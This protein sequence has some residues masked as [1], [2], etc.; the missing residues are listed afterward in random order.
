MKK[1]KIF[2]AYLPQYH[3]IPENNEFWGKGFTD[4]VGVKNA[5]PQFNGHKQPRKPLNEN[6]YDLSET[7]SIKWQA[8]L[9]R[10]YGV[11][12]FNIYHYWFEGGK[13]VLGK[14]AESILS[15]KS[16][17]IEFFF[18]WDNAS[19]VRSWGNIKG[20][21]WA[22]EFDKKEI[23]GKQTLLRFDYG[24][25]ADWKKHFDY[26]LP[27]FLDER[28]LKIN[29]SPVFC[30][31]RDSDAKTLKQMHCKWNQYAKEN[32]FDGIFLMTGRKVFFNKRVATAQ[33]TYQPGFS[34]WNKRESF[35]SRMNKYFHIEPRKDGAVKYQ[36]DFET[37]WK[38]IIRDTKI[39]IKKKI[40]FGGVVGFDDTPRR[41]SNARM[42]I[43]GSASLFEKYF[44]EFYKLNCQEN[45]EILFIT[46]WNEWG[47]GA[48]LEPDEENGYA[49]LEVIKRVVYSVKE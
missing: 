23:A 49:Y 2:A 20:N 1:T 47:E 25:E 24:S 6:Y 16:I 4:W 40:Y 34:S 39:N 43:N 41:G 10:Q 42:L 38:N 44:K 27:F 31:M 33:F 7:D 8:K 35:D 11:S 21:S 36:Y 3:E 48:Y 29:N 17:D 28:Y 5:K 12:G 45:K 46:A 37:V 15:D 26:L 32:G 22:P 18:S 13:N 14:P 19:W 30:L 9:A